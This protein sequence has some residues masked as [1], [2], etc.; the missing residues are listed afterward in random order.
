[1]P[2]GLMLWFHSKDKRLCR[3]TMKLYYLLEKSAQ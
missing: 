3:F 2:I 1:M